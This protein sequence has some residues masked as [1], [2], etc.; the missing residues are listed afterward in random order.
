MRFD[1]G[2]VLLWRSTS[3]YDMIGEN[4]IML[5]GFH[6]GIILCGKIF[7]NMSSCGKSPSDT[8]VTYR[9]DKIFPL[10][11]VVG[12]VWHRPNGASLHL[13]KRKSG[14]KIPEK[15]SYDI[16]NKY[17]NFEKY[18]FYNTAYL[19][20]AAYFKMGDLLEDPEKDEARYQ[21]CSTFIGYILKDMGIICE[22]AILTNL[23]PVDFYDLHFYQK[24]KYKLIEIFDKRTHTYEWLFVAMLEKLGQIEFISIENKKINRIL[25]KYNYPQDP[26]ITK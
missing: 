1:T 6:S 15:E 3:L 20:V 21:L 2:D 22:N 5:K 16:L 12:Q 23:L 4:T 25:R 13:V 10:E 19:A 17:L 24:D 14:R 7:E 9:V 18:D 11:E 8:Y 26:E